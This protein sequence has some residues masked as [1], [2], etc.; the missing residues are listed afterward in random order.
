MRCLS[1]ATV[2]TEFTKDSQYAFPEFTLAAM[3][4]LAGVPIHVMVDTMVLI[5]VMR[6]AAP[7]SGK[8][9]A[10]PREGGVR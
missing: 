3:W 9:P 5:E 8:L 6:E 2:L 1:A 4:A 10:D 7:L